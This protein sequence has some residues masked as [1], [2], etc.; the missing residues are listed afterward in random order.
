MSG[1]L[2]LV[3]LALWVG[4]III[5]V[6]ADR[7]PRFLWI[8]ILVALTGVFASCLP[9]V[10]DYTS[11]GIINVILLVAFIVALASLPKQTQG[12]SDH[13]TYLVL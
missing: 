2:V 6:T 13:A 9:L 8:P 12:H 3:L 11:A 10:I 1:A 7:P 5:L 4:A